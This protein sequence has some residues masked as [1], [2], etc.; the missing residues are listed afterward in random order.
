MQAADS[1]VTVIGDGTADNAYKI[2]ASQGYVDVADTSTINMQLDGTGVTTDPY[3]ISADLIARLTD[4]ANVTTEGAAIGDVLAYQGSGEWAY[5]SPVTAPVGAV[6]VGSCLQGDGS[7]G[8][9]LNVLL[10]IHP[11]MTCSPTGLHLNRSAVWDHQWSAEAGNIRYGS[12][13]F[14]AIY[15]RWGEFCWIQF[16]FSG[17]TNFY[18]G[19]DAF[20][21]VLPFPTADSVDVH[22]FPGR[23]RT[24]DGNRWIC[25]GVANPN[26]TDLQLL[27]PHSAGNTTVENMRNADSGSPG[28]G[29]GWPLISGMYPLDDTSTSKLNFSGWY[30]IKDGA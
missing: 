4:L 2:S 1:T 17:D 14:Y 23:L 22:N 26:G 21:W 12:A 6:T 8:S 25:T 3:V 19:Q 13:D 20:H 16:Q 10:D 28:A 24:S 7:G 18:G 11:G 30:R 29:H 5:Q 15:V 9:P 27:V